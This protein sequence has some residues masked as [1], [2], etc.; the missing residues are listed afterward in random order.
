MKVKL[1]QNMS[2]LKNIKTKSLQNEN[3]V[4]EVESLLFMF[5]RFFLQTSSS[6]KRSI[7]DTYNRKK[8]KRIVNYMEHDGD[9][10]CMNQLHYK[11]QVDYQENQR[12]VVA[13][14]EQEA[15]YAKF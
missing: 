1:G 14:L 9:Q 12:S 10:N 4:N 6:M 11:Y 7:H 3:D 2:K 13:L 15:E 5:A 8:G